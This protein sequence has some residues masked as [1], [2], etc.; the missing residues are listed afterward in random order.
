MLF[1]HNQNGPAWK[2]VVRRVTRRL[3]TM[4]CI[5]DIEI[6]STLQDQYLHRALP[7]GVIG[8]QTTLYFQQQD[9]P[10][11]AQTETNEDE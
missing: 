2:D 3:D 11:Q 8:T 5:E 7:E 4:E 10:P 9:S 6:N 1:N